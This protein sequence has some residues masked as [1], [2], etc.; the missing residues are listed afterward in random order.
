MAKI[1]T[2]YTKAHNTSKYKIKNITNS[3]I[4]IAKIIKTTKIQ[5]HT[6]DKTKNK[7]IQKKQWQTKYIKNYTTITKYSIQKQ[8]KQ[9]HRKQSKTHI[10]KKH[11]KYNKIHHNKQNILDIRKSNNTKLQKIQKTTTT[12]TTTHTKY[13]NKKQ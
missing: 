3:N 11:H 7:N 1:Q 8:V 12:R 6:H 5:N 10:I 9:Q 4:Q 2:K 13:K